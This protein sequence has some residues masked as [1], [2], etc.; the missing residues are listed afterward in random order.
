MKNILLVTVGGSNAPIVTSIEKIDPEFV[1]FIC[2]DD[3]EAHGKYQSGSYQGIEKS[4]P[5]QK[6]IISQLADLGK[7]IQYEIVKIRDFDNLDKCF[8][9]CHSKLLAVNRQYPD[10]LINCD[11]TGGTKSMTAALVLASQYVENIQLSFVTGLRND[12]TKVIDGTQVLRRI[13]GR[14]QNYVQISTEFESL[15]SNRQ[16]AEGE[17]FLAKNISRVGLDDKSIE[18]LNYKLIVAKG[19]KLWDSFDH[20]A[21]MQVLDSVKKSEELKIYRSQLSKIISCL[22][23]VNDNK[24]LPKNVHGYEIVQ[25]L[26]SNAIRRLDQNRFDDCIARLYRAT[27]MLFQI[28]LKKE[29]RID[30]S[31]VNKKKLPFGDWHQEFSFNEEGIAELG[32]ESVRRLLRHL[33]DSC[34]PAGDKKLESEYLTAIKK[35]NHSILAHGFTPLN[36]EDAN[37]VLDVIVKKILVPNIER[38][39]PDF[40]YKSEFIQLPTKI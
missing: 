8:D 38:F 1:V 6:S 13:D 29:H 33:E 21:T 22:D 20:R 39:T 24:E 35:R 11:Y 10:A 32:L 2:S 4:I 7:E 26:I 16:Y 5:E 12:L 30:S 15:I 34:L 23:F 28:R 27:E 14:F 3:K 37:T 19:F 40:P 31:K 36:R 25:D 17:A 9:Q 18:E